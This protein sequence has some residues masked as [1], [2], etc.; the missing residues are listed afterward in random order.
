[1]ESAF[2]YD[3]IGYLASGLVVLSLLMTSVL[4]LRVIGLFGATV[5]TA[6]GLLIGAIPV[7]VTNGVIIFVHGYHLARLLRARA[8]AAA[9]ARAARR[10]YA[11]R[12]A[13]PAPMR[14]WA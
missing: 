1:M 4:R 13:Q 10:R 7:V 6:Y 14:S 12:A 5:F 8:A 9:W 2:L 3:L 11:H